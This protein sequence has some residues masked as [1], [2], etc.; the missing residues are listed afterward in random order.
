LNVAIVIPCLNERDTIG[1]TAISLGFGDGLEPPRDTQ[2]ILVD[3][4]SSDGTW[5]ILGRLVAEAPVGAVH[6]ILEPERGFVPPRDRGVQLAAELARLSYGTAD[7]T[8]ILQADADTVY[9]PGYVERM[10]ASAR[11]NVLLEASIGRIKSWDPALAS[12][13]DL[14]LR[15]DG[16]TR[17]FEIGEDEEVLVDDKAC[18]YR[19]AD[20]VRWGG[21]QRE[22]LPDGSEIHAETSRMFLRAQVVAGAKRRRIEHAGALTS[23]RR[24]IENPTLNFATAGFPREATWLAAFQAAQTSSP[25]PAVTITKELSIANIHASRLRVGHNL[26][27]FSILPRIVSLLLDRPTLAPVALSEVMLGRGAFKRA[28]LR[29]RPGWV[30][31]TLLGMIDDPDSL[32]QNLISHIGSEL[33][34]QRDDE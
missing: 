25:G 22:Y 31:T 21:L 24:I 14:E 4:G 13:R 9:L 18:G 23:E 2:L 6:R 30:I 17:V 10:R 12:Y 29:D 3:N 20:Y 33:L 16:L 5:D 11:N 26:V 27:F 8:L 32:L 28:D 15:V 34:Y 19:L 7:E 1:T